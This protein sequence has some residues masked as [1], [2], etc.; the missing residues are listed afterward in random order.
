MSDTSLA[1]LHD[2]LRSAHA[3]LDGLRQ[4]E[5]KRLA[6]YNEIK[7]ENAH[8]RNSIDDLYRKVGRP[9]ADHHNDNSLIRKDA[10]G[11]CHIKHNWL[12]PKNDGV[13]TAYE[14]TASEIDEAI[15]ATKALRNY[16]R[17][18][19]INKI[20]SAD[21][22]KSLSSFAFGSNAFFLPPQISD[23][24][25]S[26]IVEPTDLSGIVSHTPISGGSITFPIDNQILDFA[27]WACEASCFVNNPSPDLQ[28]GLGELTIKAETLRAV[29][30]ASRDLMEDAAFPLEQWMTR[31]L[32]DAFRLKINDAISVGTGNGMPMGLLNPNAGLPICDTAASTPAN[33][34]SW[35]DLVMLAYEIPQQWWDGCSFLMNQRTVALLMTMSD[36][37]NRPL[38]SQLPGGRPGGVFAGFPVI[39]ASQFPDVAPGATPVGFGNWREA[40]TL[41][42]RKATTIQL[43][44]FSAGYCTLFKAEARLGGGILCPN[45]ARLLRIR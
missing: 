2:D 29:V 34:F 4:G 38:W 23:R 42:D 3:L 32:A 37:A 21:E 11:L 18:G 43:D 20:V 22:R 31:K 36:T 25:L 13:A 28:A 16:F 1:E 30:C 5:E 39:I 41:V 14:P 10:A 45:A 35:Q 19:N 15:S 40:Y 17:H 24:I 27:A 33:Q 12:T 6:H 9:G 8:F 26:C 7:S 44:P